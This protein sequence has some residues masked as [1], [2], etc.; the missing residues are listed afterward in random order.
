MNPAKAIKHELTEMFSG[1]ILVRMHGKTLH[2]FLPK[3]LRLDAL[4]LSIATEVVERLSGRKSLTVPGV[5]ARYSV[6]PSFEA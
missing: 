1:R 5:H 6:V 3:A 4:K 2:V